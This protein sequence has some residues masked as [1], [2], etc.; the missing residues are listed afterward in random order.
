MTHLYSLKLHSESSTSLLFVYKLYLLVITPAYLPNVY[1]SLGI[2]SVK[3]KKG[4]FSLNLMDKT[5]KDILV[6]QSKA[7]K[8]CGF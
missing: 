4:L 8:D 1:F 3:K 2:R 5:E 7:A 6:F